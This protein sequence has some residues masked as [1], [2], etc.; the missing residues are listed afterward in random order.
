MRLQLLALSLA[1]ALVPFPFPFPGLAVLPAEQIAVVPSVSQYGAAACGH[2]QGGHSGHV[3]DISGC[4]Q[5]TGKSTL[6]RTQPHL[7][8]QHSALEGW[9][10]WRGS[11]DLALRFSKGQGSWGRG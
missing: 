11:W 2:G 3:E 6:H 4:A 7:L 10:E 1:V 5:R 9:S 8:G